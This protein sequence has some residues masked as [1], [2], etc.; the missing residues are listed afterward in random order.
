ALVP[1]AEVLRFAAEAFAP[2][3]GPRPRAA[4]ALTRYVDDEK[5]LWAELAED[6]T[7]RAFGDA[8]RRRETVT[9]GLYAL[10]REAASALPESAPRL[11]DCGA[12]LAAAGAAVRGV[13]L[14]DTIDV[15]RPED[16][17][18]AERLISCF[19]A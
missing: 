13:V 6:G 15:D 17:P 12:G 19:G 1:P 2:G 18:A 10:T 5:P 4:V 16:I 8:A 9:C 7:V 3:P 11:R 14:T